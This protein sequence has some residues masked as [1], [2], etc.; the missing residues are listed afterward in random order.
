MCE[1]N[2]PL[3]W[4]HDYSGGIWNGSVQIA[5][6]I[7]TIDVSATDPNVEKRFM[8]SPDFT[9]Y[10]PLD[11]YELYNGQHYNERINMKSTRAKDYEEAT[12]AAQLDFQ[13]PHYTWH[14][15]YE[16]GVMYTDSC[17]MQLVNTD[18]HQKSLSHRGGRWQYD[19]A[20][21]RA[22]LFPLAERAGFFLASP[23]VPAFLAEYRGSEVFQEFPKK[24][25]IY[26]SGEPVFSLVQFF[27]RQTGEE[28]AGYTGQYPGLIPL[29]LDGGGNILA[30]DDTQDVF[31]LDHESA[32]IEETG[33]TLR[34]VL[35]ELG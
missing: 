13:P 20:P 9:D 23:K 34:Q 16:D 29:G 26:Q 8:Y 2:F 24:Q 4:S 30:F 35:D 14:H 3:G 21:K 22:R 25:F 1:A 5:G 6:N 27:T 17:I 19:N 15:L 28:T 10:T 18:I 11:K 33:F 32:N 7:G 12:K 31:L